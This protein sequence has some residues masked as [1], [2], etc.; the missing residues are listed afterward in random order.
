MPQHAAAYTPLG[1]LVNQGEIQ[2]G[3][4]EVALADLGQP[5]ARL[6]VRKR[7]GCLGLHVPGELEAWKRHV[8]PGRPVALP[9]L[10][11]SA[12]RLSGVALAAGAEHAEAELQLWPGPLTATAPRARAPQ[13]ARLD[14]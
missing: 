4:E 11:E 1:T 14:P 2:K 3:P 7:V 13:P 6:Q 5:M 10:A 8:V 12:L 9:R